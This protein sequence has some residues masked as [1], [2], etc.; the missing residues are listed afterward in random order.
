MG[1]QGYYCPA[2]SDS[3]TYQQCGPLQPFP[4]NLV[5]S[6]MSALATV[7]TAAYCPAG[8]PAPLP[9]QAGY[10]LADPTATTAAS[11]L[12]CLPGHYCTGGAMVR[13]RVA[14]GAVGRCV[15]AR[16]LL[17]VGRLWH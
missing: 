9:V 3:S 7:D 2:G 14:V 4:A 15:R 6:R 11:Q 13:V 10:H 17:S 16:D 12:A 1:M 5:D 8:S